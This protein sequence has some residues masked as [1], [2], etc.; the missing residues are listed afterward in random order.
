MASMNKRTRLACLVLAALAGVAPG[1]G[2]AMQAGQALAQAKACMGCHQV[3][4][5]RVGPPLREIAGRYGGQD[6]SAALAYLAN[7]IREGGRGRWG[8]IPMPAQPHVSPAEAEDLA[9]WIL[10]LRPGTP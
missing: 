3:D 4:S 9:R 10:S 6:E 8:A 2:F 1:V 7:T 5:K